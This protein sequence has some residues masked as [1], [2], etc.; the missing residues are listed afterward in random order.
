MLRRVAL[1]RTDGSEEL[2]AS[3]VRLTRIVE[4]RN[5]VLRSVRRLL[6]TGNVVPSSPILVTLMLE[7]ICSSEMSIV[8]S[9]TLLHIPE[10]RIIHIRR[11]DFKSDI[12][13]CGWALLWRRGVSPVRYELGFISKITVLF[14]VTAVKTSNVT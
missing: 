10:D 7:A 5:N 6:V 1:A 14:I 11:K 12:A 4:P 8:T 13:R 9:A 3:I 2:R